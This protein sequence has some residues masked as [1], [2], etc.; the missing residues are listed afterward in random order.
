MKTANL[1]VAFTLA[2]AACSLLPTA[3]GAAVLWDGPAITFTRANGADWTQPENQDR[4]TPLIWLTRASNQGLFNIQS[5][6]AFAHFLSPAGTEWAFGTTANFAS[7]TYTN[8]ETWTGGPPSGP[9]NTVG[10]DAVLHLTAEDIYIDIKFLSWGVGGG[11]F[12]YVRSTAPVPE[13]GSLL[14]LGVGAMLL[15]SRR[16]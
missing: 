3:R 16:R 1:L 2:T 13:P 10:R 14:L 11:S 15:T 8:W 12:S 9:P 4:L 6:T 7:L 5:E